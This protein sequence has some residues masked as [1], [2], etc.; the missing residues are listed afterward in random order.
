MPYLNVWSSRSNSS[1]L[2]HME[3]ELA[4][5]SSSVFTRLRAESW[6]LAYSLSH[7]SSCDH[8]SR[9]VIY[10]KNKTKFRKQEGFFPFRRGKKDSFG[11]SFALT[12]ASEEHAIDCDVIKQSSQS[13]SRGEGGVEGFSCVVL[14]EKRV[15]THNYDD[16]DDCGVKSEEEDVGRVKGEKV[17]VRALAKSL[18]FVKTADEVDEVLKDKVEL[19][20]QVYS[21]MIRGFGKD[22]KLNSAMALV[23]WLSRRSNDNIGSVSLNVFIYNSLLGA[24]KEAGKYDVVDKVMD[25]MVSEGVNPNVVTYNTLM[26]I[27]IEQGRELEALNLF[28]EMSKKGLFPSPATYSTALF[29]YRRLEDGLGAIAFFVETREKYQNGKLGNI[30][31]ENWESEFSKLENFTIRI[32]YQVMRQ[33]LVKGENSSTNVL[34]LLADMDKA[35]LL[36]SCAEYKRLVWAC[37]REEHYVVAKELYNRIRERDTEISLSVCNHIIWLMGKA[38]KWW[39]ALEI[40]ED[41]LDK[42]PKPNN[43]SYELIVSHFNILLS[44]ARKRGIWRWGVRLLNKMEEKGL[45]PSS[46]EWN[47]VLVACS[48]ASETSAAVQI[49]RR[50]VEKGEKPTVISYGALLSALEKGK[51]YDE[52]LQVWKHMIKMGVEPNLYAYTIMASIYTAQGKF[53]IV[54]S[55]IK[56]MVST[57]VEPTVVTFNAIISGCARNGMGSVAYEWFH[58]MKTQNITPNEVSY[59]MLIEALAND[60]KPRLAYELYIKALN[61]GLSLSTKAYDAVISS[62]QANGASIDLSILGPRP[63]EK[64]KRVQIR[65]NLSEFCNIADV[66][67]RSR[68]FDR[69]EIFTAQTKGK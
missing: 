18:H 22:K 5:S 52:A 41:L 12:Q 64:K 55:I 15:L 10:P 53:N 42:G 38:K 65:K 47:A 54:D 40:Y 57:G 3:L 39:A 35:R 20:L 19:P 25:D 37:T 45:K 31:E 63:L 13:F 34:K 29:A 27:Y 9:S 7:N 30:E 50:M 56:E 48:K 21:S 46:R 44:A 51:L 68:H 33:W 67:K 28:K 59:E 16:D 26:R 24:I 36:P 62:T 60:G 61:E 4:S 32:C 49:F 1:M 8:V 23:E 69:E 58:R 66:P 2:P 17:D 14:E 6:V 11:P 43:M